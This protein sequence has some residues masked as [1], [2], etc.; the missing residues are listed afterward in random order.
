MVLYGPSSL[1]WYLGACRLQEYCVTVP[2]H[3]R[4]FV[5]PDQTIDFSKLTLVFLFSETFPVSQSSFPLAISHTAV[6]IC[7]FLL[8]QVGCRRVGGRLMREWICIYL[9]LI[10]TVVQQKQT[11]HC[12]AIILQ[13]KNLKLSQLKLKKTQQ[14]IAFPSFPFLTYSVISQ[15]LQHSTTNQR[16]RTNNVN[17][18][19]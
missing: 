19:K 13:L 17:S 10:H 14:N 15:D 16:N 11:Q 7:Q 2:G 8:S 9:Q 12:K 4:R 5:P 1:S 18:Y 6:Y 3:L